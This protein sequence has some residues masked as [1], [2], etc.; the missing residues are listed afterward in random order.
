MA[1]NKPANAPVSEGP[2]VEQFVKDFENAGFTVTE[3]ATPSYSGPAVE[4]PEYDR[5]RDKTSVVTSFYHGANGINVTYP[6]V[7]PRELL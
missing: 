2:I 7:T 6:V 3:V 1:R 4:G 5:I